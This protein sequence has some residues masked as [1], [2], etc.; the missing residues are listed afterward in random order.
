MDVKVK[1]KYKFEDIVSAVEIWD[2]IFLFISML[3]Y[4]TKGLIFHV[5][6]LKI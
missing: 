2:Q 5:V 3:S 4:N 6:A 1:G